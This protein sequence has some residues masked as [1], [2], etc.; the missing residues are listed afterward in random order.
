MARNRS[1]NRDKAYEIYRRHDGKIRNKEIAEILGEDPKTISKW[2]TLDKWA[3]KL[4][5]E[6][7]SKKGNKK[8]KTAETAVIPADE[9]TL[10]TERQMYEVQEFEVLTE[11]QILFCI[12]YLQCFNATKAYQRVYGTN[13]NVSAACGCKLL[14]KANIQ[15]AIAKLRSNRINQALLKPEDI[16]QKFMD[17][18]FCDL[19][20]YLEFGTKETI[21]GINPDRTFKKESVPFLKLK[22]AEDVD[23][24]LLAEMKETRYGISLKTVSVSDKLRALEWLAN[25]MDMATAEQRAKVESLRSKVQV[26]QEKLHLQKEAAEANNW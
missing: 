17:I 15:L 12:Y 18:A 26:E 24:T 8:K 25:H 5:A 2:K 10:E 13:R 7:N 1:P 3:E 22:N 20:E 9:M 16:F 6:K 19:K 4:E 11:K 21:V 23:G 14:K